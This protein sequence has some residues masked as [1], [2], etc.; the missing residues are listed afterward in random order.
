MMMQNKDRYIRQEKGHWLDTW[1]HPILTIWGGVNHMMN[2]LYHT[3]FVRYQIE[4]MNIALCCLVMFL[5]NG[6]FPNDILIVS[7][8]VH[9]CMHAWLYMCDA[10]SGFVLLWFSH[11][12]PVC[13]TLI[14]FEALYCYLM[15]VS[16][17]FCWS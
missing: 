12:I 10:E 14:L 2:G 9:V 13:D 6:C 11:V 17:F 1:G 8:S 15:T 7:L 3:Q 16:V 5:M 4:C